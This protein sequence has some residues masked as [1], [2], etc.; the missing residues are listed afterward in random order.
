MDATHSALMDQIYRRQ[1]LVYDATRKFYLLGRDHALRQ[2]NPDADAN[3]LEI[4]CGTGRNLEKIDLRYPGRSL[5]GLDI[6]SEMLISAQAKLG[7]RARL[8]LGDA[9]AFDPADVF[10]RGKFDRIVMSYC[11]SMIPQW[12]SAIREAVDH[13]A[14][15]GELHI[16]DFGDQSQMPR[17]FD[18]G[19]RGWLRRFHVEPRDDL[20]RFLAS[21]PEADVTLRPLLRSYAQYACLRKKT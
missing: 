19:L 7:A 21:L 15:G 6:S 3:I 8:A 18:K 4:A 2:L 5:Y 9:C 12:Q 1:R 14:P 20:P 11:V 10:G 17:W 16:V 13:L